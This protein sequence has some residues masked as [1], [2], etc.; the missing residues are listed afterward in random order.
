MQVCESVR[1]NLSEQ[2]NHC[3]QDSLRTD[4]AVNMSC[5][6]WHAKV[7][8][9]RCLRTGGSAGFN[10]GSVL[11][12]ER[13]NFHSHTVSHAVCSLWFL[14]FC[15]SHFSPSLEA[16]F[17]API[18][19]H[20]LVCFS[21]DAF[22]PQSLPL[23]PFTFIYSSFLSCCSYFAYFSTSCPFYLSAIRIF[24]SAFLFSSSLLSHSVF[25]FI[26][27]FSLLT[28]GLSKKKRSKLSSHHILNQFHTGADIT[29]MKVCLHNVS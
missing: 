10:Y 17:V 23:T 8:T 29:Q 20:F 26:I 1:A 9:Q 3:V 18:L 22:L 27:P 15:S 7:A 24:F 2:F 19:L 4:W 6:L 12:W 11:G 13:A 5:S 21:V 16:I 14:I 28:V 25:P